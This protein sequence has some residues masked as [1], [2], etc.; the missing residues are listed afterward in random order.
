MKHED[1]IELLRPAVG[2][3]AGTTWADLGAGTGVFTRA[4]AALVGPEGHVIAVDADDHALSAVRAWA[5]RSRDGPEVTVIHADVTRPLAPPPLDGVL[6]ANT[7]H[8]VRDAA[9]VLSLVATYLRP[10][11]RFVL[12]EYEG[13]RPGPWVPFPVSAGR[14]R[15]LAAGAGLAP[16]EVVATRPSAFGGTL[17]VA[18]AT[19]AGGGA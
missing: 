2:E 17:Y 4:L 7:L 18:C 12:V 9:S 14:F 13:R 1:A 6:M 8:F 11:G 19:R 16:P 5:L 10:G 3:A 15:E